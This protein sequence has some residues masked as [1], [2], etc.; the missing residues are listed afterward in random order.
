MDCAKVEVFLVV[1]TRVASWRRPATTDCVTTIPVRSSVT[2]LISAP[3]YMITIWYVVFKLQFLLPHRFGYHGALLLYHLTAQRINWK[4]RT[5]VAHAI[6]DEKLHKLRH[7][8]VTQKTITETDSPWCYTAS[9]TINNAPAPHCNR[10]TVQH[11]I[12]AV[13]SHTPST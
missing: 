8:S 1:R 6:L 11:L 10:S 13:G 5:R 12:K 9:T 3:Y 2:E 4:L 7:A